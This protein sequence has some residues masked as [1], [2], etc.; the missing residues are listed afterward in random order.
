LVGNLTLSKM[1]VRPEGYTIEQIDALPMALEGNGSSPQPSVQLK[2]TY[3]MANATLSSGARIR[4]SHAGGFK[5][6]ICDRPSKK[7][8]DGACYPCF[9]NSAQADR[10]LLN[11]VSC[12]FTRGTCREPAWAEEFC[13]QPHYVYLAFTDKFKVGITRKGQVPTRWFDQGATMAILLARVG[14]RHQAG[15]LEHRL[16]E[17]FADKSHWIKMLKAAN[18]RP[19]AHEFLE[20]RNTALQI[21]EKALSGESSLQ[22]R[23]PLPEGLPKAA[24]IFLLNGAVL[25]EIEYPLWNAVPEKIAAVNL[26]KSP[27]VESTLFGIKGQYL[28]LDCGVFNV[29]RH[30]GYVVSCEILS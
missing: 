22:L 10:C 23:A 28:F 6:T 3:E 30:E 2:A 9:Q 8:F 24:D 12:H 5:C 19:S 4:V 29:R 11:P 7:L 26:D 25:A 16:S 1:N 27:T 18:S 20:T 15:I 13:Y 21:L 14:S 17:T